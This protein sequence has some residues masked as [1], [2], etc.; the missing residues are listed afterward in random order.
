[1]QKQITMIDSMIYIFSSFFPVFG[2]GGELRQFCFATIA[3]R[4]G[5][6]LLVPPFP[7][8]PI[9]PEHKAH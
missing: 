4:I 6:D 7:A 3:K 2:G 8:P 9:V 5:S 1:M